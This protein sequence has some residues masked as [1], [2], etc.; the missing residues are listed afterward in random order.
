MVIAIG[1]VLTFFCVAV[2]AIPFLRSRHAR[3][4]VNPV[5]MIDEL[6]RKR[7]LIYQEM[8]TLKE[9]HQVGNVPEAEFRAVYQNLRR[10]AAETLLIQGRWEERLGALD[11]A[12]EQQIVELRKDWQAQ[13]E[14]VI[15]LECDNTSPVS[16]S[17]CS[18]CG[19]SLA[20]QVPIL[21]RGGKG[22]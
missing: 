22:R 11:D 5:E 7:Q 13:K 12:L 2:I 14:T 3:E 9:S 6:I 8:A 16:Q 15:C 19:A 17:H 18:T 10:R 20:P 1:I 4:L 21:S